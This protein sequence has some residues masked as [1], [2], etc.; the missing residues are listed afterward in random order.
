MY[1]KPILLFLLCFLSLQSFAQSQFEQLTQK[2]NL[3]KFDSNKHKQLLTY[4]NETNVFQLVQLKNDS[5]IVYLTTYVETIK[6]K[7]SDTIYATIISTDSI[8]HNGFEHFHEKLNDSNTYDI[9]PSNYEYGIH[10]LTYQSIDT[11]FL[12]FTYI[13]DP[14]SHPIDDFIT[15]RPTEMY[16]RNLIGFPSLKAKRINKQKYNHVPILPRI[17]INYYGKEFLGGSFTYWFEKKQISES[18]SWKT[19]ASLELSYLNHLSNQNKLI[20]LNI[21][22]AIAKRWL[23]I[24]NVL[25]QTSENTNYKFTT[26]SYLSS[27]KLNKH[28]YISCFGGINYSNNSD[29]D[30]GL[31]ATFEFSNRK[32]KIFP[33]VILATEFYTKRIDFNYKLMW[34][35]FNSRNH[36]KRGFPVR[37]GIGYQRLFD[38][39][40]T[41]LSV[42]HTFKTKFDL[43]VH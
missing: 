20:G 17:S 14:L 2:L 12:I 40:G 27:I 42:S 24:N 3:V 30:L 39:Q 1:L 25:Y 35:L 7:K 43:R 37:I 9:Y 31:N 33:E 21:E 8:Y 5:S 26:S 13:I 15:F 11:S 19:I 36:F 28:N 4:Y 38:L 29:S 6:K 18:V 16:R 22:C 32:R 41:T 34:N 10:S 23:G